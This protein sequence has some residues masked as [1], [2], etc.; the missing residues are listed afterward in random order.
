LQ[1]LKVAG[2][3]VRPLLPLAVIGLS[4]VMAWF[5]G[6]VAFSNFWNVLLGLVIEIL[7]FLLLGALLATALASSK[8]SRLNIWRRAARNRAGAVLTGVG[9]GLALPVC[10]C[11]TASIA[12][13]VNREG[14]PVALTLVFLLAAPVINPVTLLVTYLAFEGNWLIILGRAGLALVVALSIALLLSLYPQPDELFVSG[15]PAEDEPDVPHQHH[16]H[17][18]NET[19]SQPGERPDRSA[20]V[21]GFNNFVTGTTGEFI[22]AV[23]IV[24][25]GICLASLFQTA[26]SSRI[27][28][29][30]AQGP[31]LSAL[32]FMLLAGLM[33]ICSSADAFVALS[34][35]SVSPTGS[36]LAFLVFGP[37]VNLKTIFLYRL[38]LRWRT[39]A[40]I[41]VF[42]FS[43]I[44]VLTLFLNLWVS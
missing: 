33:S 1:G 38:L 43:L 17:A 5:A 11:G 24:L 35:T 15:R 10:E 12:R 40:F 41:A 23:Q 29:D 36:I 32:V 9:M 26:I 27:F 6:P 31:L 39:I 20:R 25:P 28:L 4:V 37:L 30:L 44:L 16:N 3:W 8:F 2:E 7:P 14:A 19:V 13:R 18:E 21:T 42:C 34:F 22:E